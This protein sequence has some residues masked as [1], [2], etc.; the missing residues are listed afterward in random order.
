[1]R[2]RLQERYKSSLVVAVRF[3]TRFYNVFAVQSARVEEAGHGFVTDVL[4]IRL[5][6]CFSLQL[7]Q[8]TILI[9]ELYCHSTRNDSC[10]KDFGEGRNW[11]PLYDARISMLSIADGFAGGTSAGG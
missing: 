4:S 10:A 3:A 11:S 6:L 1:M 8:S 7:V 9:V 5:D 2:T